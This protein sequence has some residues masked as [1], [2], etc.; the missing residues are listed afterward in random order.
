M[1]IG[2][3]GHGAIGRLL[4]TLAGKHLPEVHI[5]AVLD[6]EVARQASTSG[7]AM[8]STLAGLLAHQPD[9]VVECAGHGAL[10]ALGA[11][12]LAAGV[13]LLVASVGALADSALEEALRAA[14]LAGSSKLRIPS[15]ALGGLDV[16]GA[17]RF[18]GLRSVRYE[19]RKAPAAWRGSPAEDM[20]P[21]A[22][23]SQ[24]TI[25]FQGS[26]RE[27][28]RLFPQN[29]NVA[30]AV[31]L[32]GIGFD[33]TWVSL[34]ADPAAMGNQHRIFAEGAFG[35]ID[36]R[37]VGFPLP[38]NTKTSMLAPLSLLRNLANLSQTVVVG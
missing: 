21:L 35:E 36:A 30:A 31:A 5:V 29:A 22:E 32:A 12:V 19:G 33:N 7:I 38:D 1:R 23:L 20:A 26:A 11:E 25:F 24:P 37:V 2:L 17:A 27:A 15:G 6:R 10:R 9:L 18:A 4:T 14:A 8:T 3:I 13:D 16:L 28:A 34:C